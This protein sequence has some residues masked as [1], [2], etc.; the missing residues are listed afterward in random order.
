MITLKSIQIKVI[1]TLVWA[2]GVRSGKWPKCRDTFIKGKPCAA[3][4]STKNLVVHHKVPVHLDPSRELDP[5]NLIV[6][7]SYCHFVFGHLHSFL[8]WNV[9]IVKDCEKHLEKVRNR[10]CQKPE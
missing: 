4:G 1:D 8:S 9:D 6:L 2:L 3:C 5:V 10:P 7:C